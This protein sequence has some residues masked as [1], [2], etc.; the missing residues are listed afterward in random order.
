LNTNRIYIQ[1]LKIIK[2]IPKWEGI[3]KNKKFLPPKEV[4]NFPTKIPIISL[5]SLNQTQIYLLTSNL[6]VILTIGQ[7][8]AL[9]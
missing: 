3:T 5:D 4:G 8:S 2:N 1:F 7:Y 6:R 9:F